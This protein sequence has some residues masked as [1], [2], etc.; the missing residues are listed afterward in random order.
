MATALINTYRRDAELFVDGSTLYSQEGTTQGDPL[1]MPMYALAL[2]PLIEKLKLDSSV[3]QVWYADDATAA[4]RIEKLRDWWNALV[5]LG[6]TFGYNVNPSKTHLVV[7]EIHHSTATS[8]FGDTQI[9]ITTEGKPHL[10]AALGTS[11]SFTKLYVK[12]K[13]DKW[14]E[15]LSLLSSI[16]Q[17]NPQAAYAGF[18]H[19]L[20]SKW[21]YLSRTIENIGP[22]LQPLEDII[23][24]KFIP[25]LCGGPA[26]ND[27]LRELLSLPCRLGDWAL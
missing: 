17:T 23:R 19:G 3:V 5:T 13:V 26:P 11:P 18:T 16:A 8:V 2:C 27:T 9:K 24:T 15:E 10:G 12:G 21:A 22:L 20:M 4:G 7:K 14:S 6:P 1:A 25:A